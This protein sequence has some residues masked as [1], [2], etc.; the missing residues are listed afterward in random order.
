MAMGIFQ[1]TMNGAALEKLIDQIL[2]YVPK[3][4]P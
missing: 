4:A 1:S 2:P 3:L